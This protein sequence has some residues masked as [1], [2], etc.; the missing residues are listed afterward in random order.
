MTE[1]IALPIE[2]LSQHLGIIGKT[3]GGK[4]FAARGLVE[5]LLDLKRRVCVVD[6]TGVWFG[7]RLRADGKTPAYPV[8]L[9][10]GAHADVPLHEGAGPAVA[11]F[12][13]TSDRSTVIDLDG[14]SVG[15]QQRFMTAFCEELY[16]LNTRPLHLVIEEV[17]EFAPQTG[18]P[19][20]ERMIGAVCRIFQRGRRKGF[21]AIAI[22]QRPANLHKRVLAQCNALVTLRLMA[23]QDRKAIADWI[24][25]HADAEQGAAVIDSLPKLARGQGWVFAPESGMLDRV[26][27][28]AIGTFDSMRT[29]GDD[30]EIAEPG[31][32]GAVELDELRTML[33]PAEADEPSPSKG[34]GK[35]VIDTAAVDRARNEGYQDGVADGRTDGFSDGVKAQAAL[36]QGIVEHGE[37]WLALSKRA[38]AEAQS[39]APANAKSDANYAEPMR[40]PTPAPRSIAA[41]PPRQPR[42]P[43]P[44]DGSLHAAAR[45]ML[46]ALAQNS[47]ARFTWQQTATLAGL[48]ARG[49]HYNAGKKD[50]IDRGLVTIDGDLIGADKMGLKLIGTV[51][52][53]PS[54]PREIVD[55]WCARLPAPAPEMLRYIVLAGGRA[56]PRDELATALQKQPHGGHWNGGI[57]NLRNN[58]LV[59]TVGNALK[60]AALLLGGKR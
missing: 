58:G 4:S 15:A 35:A 38:L 18:A 29:P 11:K 21:R 17:D 31:D 48:K 60:P 47:P 57:A 10:G 37:A 50:L 7:L 6:Y 42:A 19:G 25:G 44:A 46:T 40:R 3:G 16:R 30:E 1:H 33:A 49:G 36:L 59:E 8:L 34:E 41:P 52:P 28:P 51:P 12:V 55:M 5:R 23:P 45:A 9:L 20:A 27:F 24:K 54:S 56:V 32:L 13:A 14:L 26:A 2:A 39:A 43:R 22:T 53:K